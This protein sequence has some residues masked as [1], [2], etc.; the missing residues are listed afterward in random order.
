MGRV[1]VAIFIAALT[2]LGATGVASAQLSY[3]PQQ[4]DDGLRYL[5]VEG[6]FPFEPD[7][8][9][10][11]YLVRQHDPSVVVFNSSGGN[12]FGAIAVGRQIRAHGLATLQFRGLECASACA[13]AFMGGVIR[14]A[15][16]GA[17]GVH[18]SSY[19]DA[20]SVGAS[21]A[22]SVVQQHTAEIML[23]MNEMG[24]DPALMQLAMSYDADDIRYLSRREMEQ[25]RVVTTGVATQSQG[26]V[27][28]PQPPQQPQA[29]IAPPVL[30]GPDLSIPEPRSG[31]V[32]HPRG[33]ADLKFQPATDAANVSTLVNGASIAILESR[34]RWYR[35]MSGG[36]AGWLHHSWVFVDQYESGPFAQRHVQIKSFDNYREAEAFIRSSSLPL[37]AY[38]ATNGWI[39]ITLDAT[40]SQEQARELILALKANQMIP[41][42]S[43]MTYGNTYARRVCCQ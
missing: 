25:Y 1:T 3:S 19:S 14:A 23:Y 6:T 8:T 4:T 26:S 10:F 34:D 43:M 28:P 12:P 21:D 18:R 2:W 15:E 7:I 40:Y 42:D 22:V 20:L 41:D 11:N 27:P 24:V 5:L 38:L 37:R 16:P 33:Q 17:L 39:A 35:V 32:L 30:R 13:F 36:S 31:R 29:S 9:Y